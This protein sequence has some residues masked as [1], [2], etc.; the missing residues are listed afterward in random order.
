MAHL[1]IAANEKTFVGLFQALR[2]NFHFS[3]S[4]SVDF[5]PFRAG[6]AV[7]A[8]LEG[9]TVDLR[10]D[11][12]IQVKELDIKWDQ[13]DLSLGIDIPEIC[14][15]GFCIIPIPFDGCLLRA[16]RIC[17]F[18]AD[19]DINITLPLGGVITSEISVTGSLLT[20]YAV[21]PA[22]PAGMNDWDAQDSNP[23]LASHWQIVLDPQTIDLDIFDIADIVG[24]LLENALDA[25]IDNLLGFLPGWAKALI[26]AIFGPIIDLIRAILDLGDDIQEWI[27]DL[28]NVSF[29]LLDLVL[30]L[31][32]DFFANKNPIQLIEDPFPILPQA[33]N[34]NGGFPPVI[35]PVKIPI[36][37][38][39]VF[40]DDVEM[41]MEANVG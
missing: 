5:G 26:K 13:L 32:A 23:S 7:Q 3:F 19:P 37:D 24:D 40:N 8:H 14:I 16:P 35:V 2:D 17:V 20:K 15:G 38:L 41:V 1:T 21:N 31:V 18:S 25:A 10:A 11:N 39:R 4:D 12:T 36:R 30:Q 6:I 27:S 33:P 34:P 9:G 28:L 22:R 29:G